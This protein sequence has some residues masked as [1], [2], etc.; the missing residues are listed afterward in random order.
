MQVVGELNLPIHVIG[1]I[2]AAENMP[3]AN[4]YRPGDVLTTL[5]G[6][7]VEVLNTDAEGRIVMADALTYAQQYRP[8][9]IIDIATLTGA[10]VIAL[11][12]H[13]TGMISNNPSL[14]ERVR[15]AGETTGERVWQL[16]LWD[17]YRDMMKSDVADIK[18]V[19]GR[20]AGAIAAAAFLE[21]FVGEYAW[22]HLDIAGTAYQDTSTKASMPK[23]ATGV[24]VRLLVQVLL[25]MINS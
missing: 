1:L 17:A 14:A 21:H 23:G 20:D 6:K 2:S 8:H 22:V 5:S 24:G 16:P 18:N 12:S 9:G 25:D 10:M 3:G 4:A 13:A 7:T 11:G 15:Q 19:H